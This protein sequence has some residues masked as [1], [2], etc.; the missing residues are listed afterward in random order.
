MMSPSTRALVLA[1]LEKHTP[2]DVHSMMRRNL[3]T[4]PVE[5]VEIRSL[6]RSQL[7][8]GAPQHPTRVPAPDKVVK[9]RIARQQRHY[10]WLE[11][12]MPP[13]PNGCDLLHKAT[14]AMFERK[15]KRLGC[16]IE[17]A[18]L[19]T[20]YSPAQLERRLAT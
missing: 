16:S 3:S 20:L 7:R 14:E 15:A 8:N 4:E 11:K 1:L 2:A 6:R 17:A 13:Q 10:Q 5:F 19:S 12:A 18:R 9:E